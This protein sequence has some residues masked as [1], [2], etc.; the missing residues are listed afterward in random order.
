MSSTVNILS[1]DGGGIRGL[2][3][4]LMLAEIERR[5]EQP[6]SSLFD[7]VAGSSTGG[8]LCLAAV[9]ADED[10]NPRYAASELPK[11]YET[12][13]KMIFSRTRWDAILSVDKWWLRRYPDT[14]MS[15]ALT[16]LFDDATIRD[17]LTDVLIT[18]YDIE[19]RH[20]FFFRSSRARERDCCDFLMR[21]VIRATTAAPTFFEPA[22]VPN[23]KDENAP[24]ALIDGSMTSINP[25]LCAYIEAKGMY[26]DAK[27]FTVVSLGTGN[28]TKPLPHDEVRRWGLLNW[29]RPLADIMFDASSRT[30]DYQIKKLL[31]RLEDGTSCYFRYQK[32]IDEGI[33]HSMDD[34]SPVSLAMMYEW[35]NDLITDNADSLNRMC[36]LLLES[37]SQRERQTQGF[38]NLSSLA[39]WRNNEQSSE[40]NES[41]AQTG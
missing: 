21:D 22:L 30:V 2:I 6:I 34:V 5:T 28:L 20:P 9:V 12:Y 25:A 31:P 36:D 3:P 13:G 15:A 39:F 1:I 16:A 7:L 4:A 17:A 14:G 26:P 38:F 18:S 33:D 23:A 32:R 41:V 10:G 40:I 35:A 19:R 8:L 37:K 11:L 24:F 29:A 27:H